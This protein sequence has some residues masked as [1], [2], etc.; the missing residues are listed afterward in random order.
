MPKMNIT[1]SITIHS[2]VDKIYGIISDLHQWQHWSPWM[3]M[4]PEVKVTVSDDGKSYH[5]LGNRTGEGEMKVKSEKANQFVDIDLTFLKPW[6]S[7][8][9]VR[10]ELHGHGD[11]VHVN[12][13]MASSLPFFL[14][15]MKKMMEAYVGADFERGLD[16][17]KAFAETGSVPSKLEFKGRSQFEGCTYLGIKRRASLDGIDKQME[18]DFGKLWVYAEANPDNLAGAP[19]TIYHKWD[20]VKNAVEYTACLSVKSAPHPLPEGMVRGSIPAT[21][22][23]TLRHVGRYHHLGNAWSTLYAM[24]RNKEFKPV[25][26]IHPFEI[27]RNVPGEVPEEQLITDVNFAVR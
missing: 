2:T 12:W 9:D 16:M 11:H 15:W 19:F 10:I 22:I 26:N 6:K 13:H 25:K 24:H 14:F 7:H 27:Y 4:E 5:W 1:R 21:E 18:N 20:L 3:V 8:A 17:L 23:Y